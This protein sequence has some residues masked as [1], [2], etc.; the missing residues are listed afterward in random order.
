MRRGALSDRGRADC[1]ANLLVPRLPVHRRG[2]RY[3]QCRLP[4]RCR[5]PRGGS[6]TMRARPTAATSC[7]AASARP[8]APMSSSSRKRARIC[9]QP[10][11]ARW[12]TPKPSMTIWTSM[13]PSW[14]AIDPNSLRH[15]SGRLRLEGAPPFRCQ[16]PTSLTGYAM[17]PAPLRIRWQ[18]ADPMGANTTIAS[19]QKATGLLNWGVALGDGGPANGSGQ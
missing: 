14:A 13:A 2:Q 11:L 7:I 19:G 15:L 17:A 18:A 3:G 10:A 5:E 9:S 6:P 1:R 16:S 4:E 12:T 8:A